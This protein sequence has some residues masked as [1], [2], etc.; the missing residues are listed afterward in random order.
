[1]AIG[2]RSGGAKSKDALYLDLISDIFANGKAGL[3]DLDLIQKQKVLYMNAGIEQMKDYGVFLFYGTPREGQTLEEVGTLIQEEI[4]KLKTGDFDAELLPAIINNKKMS[5]IQTTDGLYSAY[6]FLDV[7]VNEIDWKDYVSKIDEMAK[8]TKQDLVDFANDFFKDNNYVTVY[9]RTGVNKDKVEVEKP[10]ITAVAIDR[11]SES[12]FAQEIAKM[13]NKPIEPVFIDFNEKIKKESI[14]EG[15]D[16]Y[17]TQN[18]TNNIYNLVRVIDISNTTDKKLALA[19]EYL[20]YLGTKKYTPEQ[21]KMEMY[22]LAMYFTPSSGSTRSYVSLYGLTETMDKSLALMEDI[23]NEAVVNQEAYDNMVQDILKERANAKLNKSI[24]HSRMVNYA[25]YGAKSRATDK[26]SEAELKSI[27][28]QE[29]IDVIKDFLAYKHLYFY[30][31]PDSKNNVAKVLKKQKSVDKLKG[32]PP[33]VEYPELPLDKPQVFFADYDMVQS[34]MYLLAKEGKFDVSLWGYETMYDNYYGSQMFS[35]IFQEV[36]EARGL[37]YT[38]YSYIDNAQ[39]ADLS[40]YI[41]FYAGCQVDKTNATLDVFKELIAEMP[42][43][44]KAFALSKDAILNNLRSDRITKG[45]IFWTY[46]Y[47]KDLGIDYDYR[48]PVFEAV[49]KMQLADLQIYFNKYIKPA[50]YSVLLVGK[51]DKIDFKYLNKIAKV[52]ELTLEELF[53]Y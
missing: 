42:M 30:Y 10:K 49:E 1:V 15:V 50:Q 12:P 9:K 46:L 44:E 34:N 41:N 6:T 19:F 5:I 4:A 21:L 47:L 39:R 11:D 28:P 32:V 43:S 20:P 31:G 45:N 29:L 36:R 8:I 18:T 51:K 40:S 35:V 37:A 22:K 13:G 17:Y 33:K 7:F 52:K 27:H 38:A 23:M 48:K 24:I 3:I 14:S 2:Y 16:F 53:G 26:L 25:K